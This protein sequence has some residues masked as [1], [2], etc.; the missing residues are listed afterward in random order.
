MALCAKGPENKINRM[1]QEEAQAIMEVA[2]QAYGI[3]LET[4]LSFKY[5]GWVLSAS[6]DNW[7]AVV[8]NLWKDRI[9]WGR[10]SSILVQEE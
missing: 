3:S 9:I 6:Y 4:V 1:S 5:L 2:F 7:P 10:L 8:A